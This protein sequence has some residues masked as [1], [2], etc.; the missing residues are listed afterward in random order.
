[1]YW[2]VLRFS[3]VNGKS[4]PVFLIKSCKP[5]QYSFKAEIDIMEEEK[6]KSNSVSNWRT[7]MSYWWFAVFII[8]C[9]HTTIQKVRQNPGSFNT[10]RVA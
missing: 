2:H 7:D 9:L 5:F 8:A 6:V 4:I 1:M 10:F 3:F